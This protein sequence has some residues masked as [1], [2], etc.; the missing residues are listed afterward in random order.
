MELI[1]VQPG[2]LALGAVDLSLCPN[3]LQHHEHTERLHVGSELRDVIDHRTVRRVH[4]RLLREA[5][6]RSRC[7]ELKGS[8]DR[9]RLLL[10]LA[11]QFVEQ[12]EQSWRSH[13]LVL[14]E[15]PI[16]TRHTAVDN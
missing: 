6:E 13:S 12:V 15:L 4:I 8:C 16:Y 9:P 1:Q 14:E 3:L 7:V 2:P 10:W 11:P 5:R